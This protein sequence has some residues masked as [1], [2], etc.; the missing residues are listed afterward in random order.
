MARTITW[1]L[2]AR[3]TPERL[4]QA[5]ADGPDDPPWRL[6]A[7]TAGVHAIVDSEPGSEHGGERE[8]A[9]ELSHGGLCHVGYTDPPWI[10]TCEKGAWIGEQA[11][12]VLA[13]AAELG[14]PLQ[15]GPRSAPPAAGQ[16]SVLRAEG[17]QR[18]VL[19]Q[20][21]GL[22]SP[23]HAGS[24]VQLADAG[25]G[26]VAWSA[27]AGLFDRVATVSRKLDTLVRGAKRLPDGGVRCQVFDRGR[28]AGLYDVPQTR[29]SEG[30]RLPD[31]EGETTPEGVLHALGWPPA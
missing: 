9:L 24:D 17:V 8:L 16:L 12:D 25:G 23:A 19:A 4:R 31:I 3:A 27:S 21:L 29:W 30:R 26:A 28:L 20:A 14:C 6:V 7:G 11:G 2:L 10:S 1:A 18:E 13:L 15:P 5:I 22:D